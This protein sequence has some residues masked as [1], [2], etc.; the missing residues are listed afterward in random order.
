MRRQTTMMAFMCNPIFSLVLD[1]NFTELYLLYLAY[2]LRISLPYHSYT[3]PPPL[4]HARRRRDIHL[5]P[6]RRIHTRAHNSLTCHIL[7]LR[8]RHHTAYN[9]RTPG[10]MRSRP[11]DR[12]HRYSRSIRP[13][14]APH[15]R[16]WDDVFRSAGCGG[17]KRFAGLG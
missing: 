5:T 14:A 17:C 7:I 9:P 12:A 2:P 13:R 1:S 10:H 11:N 8:T 4:P 3:L 15:G 6:T 16:A